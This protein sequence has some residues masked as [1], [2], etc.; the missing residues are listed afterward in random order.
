MGMLSGGR[1]YVISYS[2][3]PKQKTST[4]SVDCRHKHRN[5][6]WST[7]H[8][9]SVGF[10][11][12]W[13]TFTTS[14]EMTKKE[15]EQKGISHS[16]T[17]KINTIKIVLSCPQQKKKCKIYMTQLSSVFLRTLIFLSWVKAGRSAEGTPSMPFSTSISRHTPS[18]TIT[19]DACRWPK[20]TPPSWRSFRPCTRTRTHTHSSSDG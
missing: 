3:C 17:C 5:T 9:Y 16:T 6:L 20:N 4:L 2:K 14:Q 10:R 15:R 7:N 19:L 18:S 11:I 8:L 12:I 1:P 13:Q